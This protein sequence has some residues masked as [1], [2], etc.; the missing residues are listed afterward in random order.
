MTEYCCEEFEDALDD[1]ISNNK[2]NVWND[3]KEDFKEG[4]YYLM[5]NDCTKIILSYPIKYCPFCGEDLRS[6]YDKFLEM[7]DDLD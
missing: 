7:Q 6:E 5:D 4:Q 3:Q 1:I 2:N